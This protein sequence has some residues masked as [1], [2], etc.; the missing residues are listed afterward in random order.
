MSIKYAIFAGRWQPFHKGHLWVAEKILEKY[1]FLIMGIVNPIPQSPPDP[2]YHKFKLEENPFTF[3]ERVEM[4]S[5]L[6]SAMNLKERVIYIPMWH[7]RVSL[8]KEEVYLP[9]HNEREWIVPIAEIEEYKK[10]EDFCNLGEKV[11]I[12]KDIPEQILSYHAVSL[13]FLITNQDSRWKEFIPEQI[14]QKIIEF[15]GIE[16]IR[17]LCNFDIIE[18]KTHTIKWRET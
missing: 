14:V 10:A 9:P 6:F 3:W 18:K 17:E 16:R 4:L 11:A 13:R 5:S 2:M 12:I 15:N 1:P 8:K 7:P